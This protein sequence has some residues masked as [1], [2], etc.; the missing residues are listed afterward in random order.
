M[1]L[2]SQDHYEIMEMFERALKPGRTDKEP[3]SLWAKGHIYQD[4]QVNNLFLAF[5]QGVAYGRSTA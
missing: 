1:T 2:H 5:R 4:G 3:K